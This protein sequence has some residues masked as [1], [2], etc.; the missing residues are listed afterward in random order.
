L[1]QQLCLSHC[2]LS[3]HPVRAKYLSD[4]CECHQMNFLTAWPLNSADERLQKIQFHSLHTSSR[5]INPSKLSPNDSLPLLLC[6]WPLR[7][8]VKPVPATALRSMPSSLSLSRLPCP[9]LE[10]QSTPSCPPSCVPDSF[11]I[12]SSSQ[13]S[14]ED[15][16]PSFDKA[17]VY[18]QS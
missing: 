14:N 18:Y 15:S 8:L 13:T 5:T 6:A 2:A 7:P 9:V 11:T 12:S 3:R 16:I 4:Q 1:Y 17:S 10:R